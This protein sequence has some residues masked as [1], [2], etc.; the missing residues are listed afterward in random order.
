MDEAF[1]KLRRLALLAF[2]EPEGKGKRNNWISETVEPSIPNS[3]D[4][5]ALEGCL[6]PASLLSEADRPS[7]PPCRRPVP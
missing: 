2:F 4:A 1:E 3:S 5:D 6:S 7:P